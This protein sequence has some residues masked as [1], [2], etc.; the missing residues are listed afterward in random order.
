MTH[1]D[2]GMVTVE[3]ALVSVLVA[4]LVALVGWFGLQLAFFDQC[5]VAA[6]EVARQAARGDAAA[7]T[8]ASAGVPPG[9]VVHLTDADGAT[10]VVVTFTPRLLG[11]PTTEL[12]ARATV[13]DEVR[14]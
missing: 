1:N 9:A 2:R 11:V 13:L 12:T 6:D 10:T 4:G 14:G 7:V 3:L 8:R 5:Q